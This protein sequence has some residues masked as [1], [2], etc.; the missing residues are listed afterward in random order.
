[1]P[2]GIQPISEEDI[3]RKPHHILFWLYADM[4][5]FGKKVMKFSQLDRHACVHVDTHGER[6]S[7]DDSAPGR[8][9]LS[10][11]TLYC[12]THAGLLVAI[13]TRIVLFKDYVCRRGLREHPWG[14]QDHPVL[15]DTV[16]TSRLMGGGGFPAPHPPSVL[17]LVRHLRE[18]K[19]A[20]NA[21]ASLI[22]LGNRLSYSKNAYKVLERGP[23]KPAP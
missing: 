17:L 23:K 21:T 19:E 16:G 1:M 11:E 12:L 18:W 8:R 20:T 2:V 9:Y 13:C 15:R 22:S 6:E 14:P 3:F 4:L 5:N 7:L 10:G